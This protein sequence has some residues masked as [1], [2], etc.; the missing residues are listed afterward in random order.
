VSNPFDN[1]DGSFFVL[2]NAEGQH[3]LWPSFIDVPNGWSVILPATGRAACLEFVRENWTDM[4]PD[5]L[6]RNL[7][8]IA[9]A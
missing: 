8:N 2:I 4:R 6:I 3:S 7:A 9:T 1:E 5:S